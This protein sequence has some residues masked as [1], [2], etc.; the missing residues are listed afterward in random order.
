MYCI[1]LKCSTLYCI[2]LY[3][4]TC[5]EVWF[6]SGYN[7]ISSEIRTKKVY[8]LKIF[9]GV[10]IIYIYIIFLFSDWNLKMIKVKLKVWLGQSYML[11]L[12]WTFVLF[13]N[14]S[15]NIIDDVVQYLNNRNENQSQ[16]GP[17]KRKVMIFVYLYIMTFYP[18]LF[19]FWNL[20]FW[21]I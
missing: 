15:T 4:N 13:I 2:V 14:F 18:K 16:L 8:F 19:Y 10:C 21:N 5:I 20:I 6:V 12:F 11:F 17:A 7:Y 9:V 1:V 3:F